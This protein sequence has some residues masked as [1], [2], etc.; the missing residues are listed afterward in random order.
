MCRHTSTIPMIATRDCH[1][2]PV[3]VETSTQT[4]PLRCESPSHRAYSVFEGD[5]SITIRED[6]TCFLMSIEMPNV[7]ESDIQVSLQRNVLTISGYR[8][9]SIYSDESDERACMDRTSI[10]RQR[11]S[12]EIEVDPNAIDI[13]RAMASTW[14]GCYTLYAPKRIPFD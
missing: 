5:D 11:L 3:G 14:N 6:E 13:Q 2:R 4:N 8:R 1:P 12:R 7:H 9:S 10:K